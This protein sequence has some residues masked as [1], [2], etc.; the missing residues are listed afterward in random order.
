VVDFTCLLEI[1][2]K[3]NRSLFRSVS[4]LEEGDEKVVELLL[5]R[6]ASVT[7]ID[8]DG[9]SLLHVAKLFALQILKDYGSDESAPESYGTVAPPWTGNVVPITAIVIFLA[10]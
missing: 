2:D 9:D 3:D 7:T 8:N 10:S 6:G 5:H 1:K 4:R